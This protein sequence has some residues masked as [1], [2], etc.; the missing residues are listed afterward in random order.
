KYPKGTEIDGT[1]IRDTSYD[2]DEIHQD[3][4]PIVPKFSQVLILI[5]FMIATMPVAILLKKELF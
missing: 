2:V 1:G 4:Y 3:N 5:L